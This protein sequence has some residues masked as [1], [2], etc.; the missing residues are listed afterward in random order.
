MIHNDE[1]CPVFYSRSLFATMT[2]T[3]FV[4]AIETAAAI[5]VLRNN[6]V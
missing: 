3:M 2:R 1:S 4:S 5:T 6:T